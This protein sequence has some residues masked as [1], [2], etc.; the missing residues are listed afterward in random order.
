MHFNYLI[1]NEYSLL[2]IKEIVDT[3]K[4]ICYFNKQLRV[5]LEVIRAV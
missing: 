3:K 2:N 1:N 4:R 5:Y